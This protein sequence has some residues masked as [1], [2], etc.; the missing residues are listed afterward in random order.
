MI[1]RSRAWGAVALAA[2][3]A[4]AACGSREGQMAGDSAVAAGVE[5]L[6][7]ANPAIG[8]LT[9]PNI[10]AVLDETNVI[11]S[12]TGALAAQ[13]GTDREVREYGQMM[14]TDHHKMRLSGDSLAKRL[15]ITPA[16]PATDTMRTAQETTMRRLREMARGAEW[17]RAYIDMAVEMH[18]E[19]LGTAEQAKTSTE[20]V[21][22]EAMIDRARPIIQQHL[23]R[24]E[25]IQRRIG[26]GDT[27]RGA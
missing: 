4:L 20:N 12:A 6:A 23:D 16:P 17:D 11:D 24:A 2:S 9:D 10:L 27:A 26:G 3:A 7:A 18:R 1:S 14:V 25:A 5:S 15:S 21:E 19:A 8:G 13:K 22:I